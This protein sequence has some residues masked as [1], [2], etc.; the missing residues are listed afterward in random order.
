MWDSSQT[1]LVGKVVQVR[2]RLLSKC[3]IRESEHI[4]VFKRQEFWTEE[5]PLVPGEARQQ[6]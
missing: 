4:G 5:R 3:V 1:H 2:H 6:G